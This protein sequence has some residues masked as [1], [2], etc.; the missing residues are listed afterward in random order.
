MASENIV[1][2]GGDGLAGR[3]RAAGCIALARRLEAENLGGSVIHET[4]ASPASY[5]FQPGT[6]LN[7]LP[8]PKTALPAGDQVFE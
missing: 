7:F 1:H 2:H 6:T 4:L 5:F 3:A 8:S